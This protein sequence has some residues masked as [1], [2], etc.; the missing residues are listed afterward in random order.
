[1]KTKTFHIGGMSCAACSAAVTRVVSRLEGVD[2]CDVNLIT[3]KMTVSFDPKKVTVDM[4]EQTVV[5]AGFTA[6]LEQEAETPDQNN[7]GRFPISLIV[8]LILSA[9]LLYVSMGQMWFEGLPV[10]AFASLTK[11]P[12]GFALTQLVL[13]VP[14]LVIGRR[15]FLKGIPSLF[16]GHP[17]MDTLVALGSGASFLYSVVM[18]CRIPVNAH[19]VHLLYYES[20]AVVLTLI[21]LGKHLEQI[22]R[23]RTSAA[24][25]RLMSLAPDTVTVLR[26]GA[27]V[28]IPTA[29]AKV[30]ETMLVAA[31]ENI[32]LDGRI[33]DGSSSV[34]ESMLT[35]ESLPV[36]KAVGD[37]VTGG[38]LNTNGA[39]SVEITHIGS[40]TTLAK[41]IRFVEEAQ[42]K[43]APIAKT[44]DKI[45][46][47][48]VPVVLGIAFIATVI[49]LLFDYDFSFALRI[50]TDVLVI[51]C[52]CS[53]GLA[54]PTA[55]MVGTGLGAN[56][57][58]L[59]R[60]GEALEVA[61]K[62]NVAVFD[63]TGTL[64]KGTPTVTDLVGED[65][66]KLLQVAA[67]VEQL[68]AHPLA[69]AI[70]EYAKEKLPKLPE[71][72]SSTAIGGKG[73]TA[74]SKEGL[75]L[76][77][78][79]ALLVENGLSV[80]HLHEHAEQLNQNGKTVTFV[81]LE[82]VVL[83]LLAISDEIKPT[84]KTA[85][86]M[87]REM[88]IRTV[89]LSGD[90]NT[91]AHAVAETLGMDESYGQVLPEQKAQILAELKEK[92]GNVMM[93]GDGINDTPAIAAADI[94]CAIGN[95][96]DIAIES[97]DIVLMKNDPVDVARA[98]KLS[99]LTIRN[100]RQNL[101]WAFC[102]NSICIPV[103]AGVLYPAFSLLLNP[104]LAGLAMSF[105]SLFV[106]GNALRLNLK[107]F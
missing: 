76:V 87:L 18:T 8:C 16:S 78:N 23:H 36:F 28:K 91:V 71:P 61:H 72:I 56:H 83:G 75:I 49:W 84:A 37:L 105:S 82:N 6:S 100:I 21:M 15:F 38:S 46:G 10:P 27:A 33:I 3:E 9:V 101:F 66:E 73:L 103:A 22:S 98:V 63:K 13:T 102:Y 50:F 30:G 39:L 54:T 62:T 67:A 7:D 53:L 11:H 79:E 5:R 47:F 99:R 81:A 57:G 107:K 34:D 95:G 104:M 64:T 69:V 17:S 51:A 94:G 92:Y 14:V 26:D 52:P 40:D 25:R 48:F 90:R 24:I 12:L 19:A 55:I 60:N 43:K 41:I 96:S 86:S 31:G 65:P 93:V 1:M 44:A 29:T 2:L 32:P 97:A 74:S 70:T 85:I 58:I 80:D 4:I 88:G 35:G 59:I 77:G 106:V 42:G 45:A 20:A 68:S 89:L